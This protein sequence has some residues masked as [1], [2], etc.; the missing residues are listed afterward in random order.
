MNLL[1]FQIVD[2][3]KK[4]SGNSGSNAHNN[5]APN[6][7]PRSKSLGARRTLN[8]PF[9]L[10]IKDQNKND[11]NENCASDPKNQIS[12]NDDDKPMGMRHS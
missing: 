9:V 11:G 5:S 10:P 8:S 1:L 6:Y 7:V 3:R 4:N 12:S 2:Q